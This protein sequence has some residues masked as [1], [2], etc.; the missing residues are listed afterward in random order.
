VP[1]ET[2]VA[3][4]LRLKLLCSSSGSEAIVIKAVIF[5]VD[6]TL[7]NTVDLHAESWQDAFKHF[8][9]YIP[10]EKVRHQIGKGGDQLMPVFLS[11]EELDSYGKQIEEYRSQLYLSEYISRAR[12]FPK[13][14]ELFERIKADGKKIALASSAKEEELDAYKNLLK[15]EDLV[16]GETN[17]DEVEKSKPH[18]DVFDAALEKVGRPSAEDVIIIGDTPYDAQAA[19]K[20]KLH[21]IGLLCG[22]FP[23]EELRAA[24]CI[25]IFRDP[26]DLLARYEESSIRNS[27][28]KRSARR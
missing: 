4:P 27:V 14:R 11:K 22:G 6:G 24:G 17:A 25:E 8:G 9:F 1:F 13:V 15:I 16:E 10:Y 19:G 5:D 12:P 7:V 18:P 26:A 2:F 20:L 3:S 23:E 21:T 28:A